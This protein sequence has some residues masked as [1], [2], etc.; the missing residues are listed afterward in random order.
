M[1]AV[2]TSAIWAHA[3][4]K[5]SELFLLLA[6]AHEADEHGQT[7]TSVKSLAQKTR[8]TPRNVQL[9]THK[10]VQRGELV[11]TITDGPH[12]TN[13]YEAKISVP[14]AKSSALP[15]KSS[16]SGKKSGN[17]VPAV[18]ISSE[19]WPGLVEIIT[20]FGLPLESLNDNEWW[21]D[22]SWSCNNPS[23]AWL[24]REFAKMHAWIKENP[25][26][27]PRSRWQRFVRTWLE[28]TYE[29]ERKSHGRTT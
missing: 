14:L 13:I 24:T 7:V 26:K 8:F 23:N 25:A 19:D 18:P 27:A 20:Q 22:I 16:A 2:L 9:L 12:G 6:I 29:Q 11:V 21:N 15:A 1:S 3:R 5:G 4:C 28:R 17:K 10:L